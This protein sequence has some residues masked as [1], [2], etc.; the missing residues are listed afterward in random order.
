MLES[1]SAFESQDS[2]ERIAA[3]LGRVLMLDLVIRNEDRLPCRQLR[4]RG[5]S[6]NLLLAEKT[7]VSVTS[8]SLEKALDSAMNQYRPR[9]LRALQKERRS[10][11]VSI[12]LGP[13]NPGLF[14]QSSDTSDISESPTCSDASLEGQAFGEPQC[15][16]IVAIDSGVPRRPPAGK[17][18]D[19]H[20]NYPKLVELLINSS[21]FCSNLLHDITGGKLGSPSLEEINTTTGVHTS[22]TALVV[23][24]FR[25]GFRA[26]LRDLQGF[27][28]FLLTL[29]QKLD[30]LL[31]SFMNI[32][33]KISSGE[34]DKEDSMVTDSPSLHAGDVSSP[35]PANK[36]RSMIDSHP[37]CGD[38]ESQRSAS[39]ASW[40]WNKD[41]F[42]SP[43]P[44]PIS[45]EGW[46]GKSYK[47]SGDPVRSSLRL[48]AKLRDFH[49][50]A[51]VSLVE[52]E[53]LF[54]GFWSF[55]GR[56]I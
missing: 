2:A 15:T 40:L 6:A 12:R 9:V 29:H 14:S 10:T 20:A 51:K 26:A 27:H 34:C 22:E 44:S 19:D 25:S 23:H 36:D 24:E 35:S 3:A 52:N 47:G 4:W 37:D 56:M 30:I 8:N 18:S 32:I 43:S 31:R 54:G 39:R 48:T 17:R 55:V 38:S 13:N 46:H 7:T 11:S 16:D 28:M 49:K 5:N 33:S 42:D 50:Y 21:E 41:N 53:T 45:R 1:S